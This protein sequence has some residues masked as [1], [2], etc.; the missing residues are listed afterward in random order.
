MENQKKVKV[1]FAMQLLQVLWLIP[2]AWRLVVSGETLAGLP[3]FLDWFGLFAHLMV[4]L[5]LATGI[6]GAVQYKKLKGDD[7]PSKLLT[8]TK[9][10]S[11]TN[12]VAGG[13]YLG[14]WLLIIALLH[15]FL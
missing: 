7:E 3:K 15:T 11:V 14:M 8:V 1:L 6:L 5:G 13:L 2:F 12:I 4:I 9:W 10:L